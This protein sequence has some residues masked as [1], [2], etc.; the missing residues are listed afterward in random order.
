[1]NKHPLQELC[2]T[3]K[4]ETQPYMHMHRM[5]LAVSIN[6]AYSLGDFLGEVIARV[7]SVDQ[8][9]VAKAFA[10]VKFDETGKFLIFPFVK[11]ANR[12]DI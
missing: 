8:H 4:F 11:Y 1:M 7:D 9:V 6:T 10:T 3:L 12:E 5:C 2:E